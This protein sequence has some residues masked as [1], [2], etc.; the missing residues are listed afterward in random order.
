[1]GV[2][3]FLFREATERPVFS[4]Q[5]FTCLVNSIVIKAKR[6]RFLS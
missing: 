3:E 1:M 2:L 6:I 5:S 4:I